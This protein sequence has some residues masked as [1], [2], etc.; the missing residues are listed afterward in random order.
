MFKIIKI[1][2]LIAI[3]AIIGENSHAQSRTFEGLL[4]LAKQ[5]DKKI[6]VDVYTD[7]CGWCKKMDAEAY[8]NKEIKEIIEDDFIFVRL[9]AEGSGKIKYNGKEYTESDLAVYFEV[10][11]YPTTVFL[12]PNG[13]VIE[14]EY[15]KVKMK[16]LPGYFKTSEF[17]KMLNYIKDENY[18]NTDLSKI[19]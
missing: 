17:K 7:W 15:D 9:N 1:S 5:E 14:Y 13:K 12:E 6:I 19:L 10:T 8:S 18:K 11:G 3:I 2:I 4:K 16:N